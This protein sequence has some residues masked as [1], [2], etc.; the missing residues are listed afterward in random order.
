MSLGADTQRQT[1]INAGTK[2]IL[3]DQAWR[4]H[5]PDLKMVNVRSLLKEES[6][7]A[8]TAH[9]VKYHVNICSASSKILAGLGMIF[10]LHVQKPHT[11]FWTKNLTCALVRVTCLLNTTKWWQ[12]T[13]CRTFFYPHSTTSNISV[14]MIDDIRTLET[15]KERVHNIHLELVSVV[16]SSQTEGLA[17]M[18][19][20]IKEEVADWN[21]VKWRWKQERSALYQKKS[22]RDDPLQAAVHASVGRPKGKNCY[23]AKSVTGTYKFHYTYTS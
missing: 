15:L 21:T 3:R 13:S 19:H 20:L 16:S 12:H 7:H 11:W 10:Y 14:V 5:V 6:V 1:H 4:P 17:T 22:Q 9:Y 8:H 18:K 23:A 2:T